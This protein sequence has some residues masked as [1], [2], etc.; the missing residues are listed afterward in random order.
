MS[1]IF[2]RNLVSL[3]EHEREWNFF[4][5]KPI[6]TTDAFPCD[7]DTTSVALTVTGRS[8][9]VISSVMDEMLKY[10]DKDGIVQV[11]QRVIQFTRLSLTPI[12]HHVTRFPRHTLIK[13]DCV[14]TL[15]FA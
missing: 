5:G 4:Q 8:K 6:L 12:N 14:S 3:E 11:G 10:V 9:E 1:P 2:I 15:S 13:R 7:L